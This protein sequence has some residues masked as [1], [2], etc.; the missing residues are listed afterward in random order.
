MAASVSEST[1]LPACS[2]RQLAGNIF[3]PRGRCLN[4]A[5]L[6]SCQDQQ[7]AS[8][9]FPET[10]TRCFG[11]PLCVNDDGNDREGFPKDAP[12]MVSAFFDG[13]DHDR[14]SGRRCDRVAKARLGERGLFFARHLH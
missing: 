12:A 14:V 3:A 11:F 10:E 4:P 2:C 6:A 8:L 1:G 9:C 5:V 7:A 13:T